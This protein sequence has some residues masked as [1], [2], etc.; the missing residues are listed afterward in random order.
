MNPTV[1]I[2][3][4]RGMCLQLVMWSYL[5]VFSIRWLWGS[6][7]EWRGGIPMVWLKHDSWPRRTWYKLWGGTCFGHGIMLSESA[8]TNTITHEFA[9][10]E[11]LE[12][13]AIAGLLFGIVCALASWS[14]WPFVILYFGL[15][16]GAYLSASLTALIRGESN[17]YRG[18]HFEEAASAISSARCRP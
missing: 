6:R 11:Q 14:V 12:A 13:S 5:L 18:N 9:H 16:L 8:S 1:S 10:V 2:W 17:A 3:L 7:I 15:P 4:R